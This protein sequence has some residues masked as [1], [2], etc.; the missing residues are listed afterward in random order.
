MAATILALGSYLIYPIVILILTSFNTARDVMVGPTQWGLSN[1]TTAWDR[2]NIIGSLG[3]SVMIWFLV[4]II[5]VPVAVAISLVLARTNI[6]CS[7]GLEFMFWIAF[8]FPGI[9]S[10]FGWMILLDPDWGFINRALEWLPFIDKGPFNIYSIPGIV[11]A[12]LMADGI[13]FKVI[14][15]TPAFRNMDRALEESARVSG[16]S[17]LRTVTKVTLPVM[18]PSIVLVVSLQLIRMFQGF[19]VE[20]LLGARWGFYVYSTSIYQLVRGVDIPQYA[21]AV[22][23]ASITALIIA[24]IVPVQHWVIGRRSHTTVQGSFK[25]GLIDLGR[26]KWPTFGAIVTLLSALTVLPTAVLVVGSFMS[27]VGFFNATPTWTL[28]HWTFVLG[29]PEFLDALRTTLILSLTAGIVSPILFSLLAYMIVRTEWR[30][31]RILDMLIWGSASMPG[32]LVG[33]GLLLMFLRTPGLRHLFGTIWA[34]IIVVIVA[35][36]TTGVNVLKGVLVQVGASLEE[37]GR[38]SGAGWWRTY[39]RIVIPVL[40]PTMVLVGMLN[41]VLAAGMTSSI[42]LLASRETTTLSILALEWGS[43]ALD[44]F[45]AAGIIGLI[46][47]VLTL[48]AALPLRYLAL[49]MGVRHDRTRSG[50]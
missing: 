34:L 1:W 45:E 12:R 6:P 27:R 43:G 22:V 42:I 28:D 19:E 16:A 10:T 15:L 17:N 39:T 8:I 7:H 40:M 33:L 25:P 3:N 47:T 4:A 18:A 32:I 9:S 41:F 38:V 31:R 20:Y 37:A 29:S 46:T 14:L 11:W 48:S 2:P 49:R 44:E 30:G 50:R 24:V 5:A 35:G 13:A 23:L 36:V 21:D 26:C